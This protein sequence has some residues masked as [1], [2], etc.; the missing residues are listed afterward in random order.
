MLIKHTIIGISNDLKHDSTLVKLFESKTMAIIEKY[1][2]TNLVKQWSDGCA[3]QYKSK[4][5]QVGKS[6]KTAFAYLSK[7]NYT[8][9]RNFFET[10]HG[11]NVRGSCEKL[12]L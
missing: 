1:T 12:L 6:C 11:K 2:N 5:V 8:L 4:K 9:S 3:A 10:S 7:R